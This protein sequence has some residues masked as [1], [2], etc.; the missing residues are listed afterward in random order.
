MRTPETMSDFYKIRSEA[1]RRY[2]GDKR[3]AVHQFMFASQEAAL[4][5]RRRLGERA[6]AA[7][8]FHV[9]CGSTPPATITQFDLEA[10]PFRI[11]MG[12]ILR[13]LRYQRPIETYLSAAF[14]QPIAPG[15]AETTK[16]CYADTY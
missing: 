13:H 1:C 11:V 7:A 4:F 3:A 10:P 12:S 2:A 15:P 5:L 6:Y 8:S 14:H 16:D 9:L